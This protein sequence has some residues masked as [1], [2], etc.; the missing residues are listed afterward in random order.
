MISHFYRRY[1]VTILWLVGLSFPWLWYQSEQMRSN[2]D[3]ETWLP[4]DTPVRQLY[5]EFKQDFGAEEVIV[6]GLPQKLATAK[7]VEA[8]AGRL[9]RLPGIRHCWTPDRMIGR[10]NEFGV[11]NAAAR[12]RL[13]GLLTSQSGDLIGV[14]CMLSELGVKDRAQVVEDVKQ[15][16]TYCQFPLESV[17][18]TGAPVI[19]TELDRLGSQKSSRQFFLLTCG[20]SLGL[21][22]YS[23]GHMGLSLATLGTALWGIF[24]NQSIMLLF[25]GEMN[26]IMGSLAIMVMIFTLSISVHVVSYYDS[27]RKE[28]HLEP[29]AAAVKESFS[30]CMLSTLTTLLGLV[31]LNV[32]SILPV[33]QFGYAAACGSIVALFVGLGVTPALLTVLP[34]CTVRSTRFHLDFRKWGTAVAANRWRILS[35]AAVLLAVTAIGILQLKPSINP[36]EFLPRKSKILADLNRIQD[37]LTN[38]DSIEAVVDLGGDKQA[39]VDQLQKVRAIEAKIAAHPGVRHTLSLAMFFPEEMPDNTRAA[40][41]ILNLANSYSGDEGL[42]AGRQRLWRISARIRHDIPQSPVE[43]LNDLTEQLADEPVQFTGLTP[44]LKN[45]QQQIFDGFWQSF[46]A[47]VLTISLVMVLSLRSIT[48]AVIAMIPNII[49]I[50]L[51]FGGVGFLGMPVDIGMMMTGSIALGIS[52]DCTFHFLVKYQAAYRQGASSTEAVCQSLEHSGEPMLDSTLISALGMLALCLSSFAPT[53]RFGCLMAAQMMASLLG[54]LV[55]LPAMLSCRPTRRVKTGAGKPGTFGQSG[56][57]NADTEL[58]PEIHPFPAEVPSVPR[59][60]RTAQ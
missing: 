8:F 58:E 33:S 13:N 4:R 35:S 42:V 11:E 53:A 16:L 51:V 9:E 32:S 20:I 36:T 5:E 14:V 24:L 54:E 56:S 22:Y 34:N 15:T 47:A 31:S 45:A 49:P 39:F 41:R 29:L 12:Q 28:G 3:I 2:N 17:A 10:M 57:A 52:V 50:W 25:G 21:L 44:L 26:F 59:R 19:V 40:A 48:A 23:F 1:S 60:I 7:L 6:I 18:L 30:P 38:I 37:D 43:V 46:T 55:L 27:A